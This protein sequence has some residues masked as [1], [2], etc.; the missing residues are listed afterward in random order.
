MTSREE[1]FTGG[2][3]RRGKG[4]MIEEM[5][6]AIIQIGEYMETMCR[7]AAAVVLPEDNCDCDCELVGMCSY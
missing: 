3:D 1:Q 4:M 2:S 5:A 6:M 7:K